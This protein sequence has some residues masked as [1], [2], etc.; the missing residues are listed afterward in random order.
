MTAGLVSLAIAGA[1]AVADVIGALPSGLDDWRRGAAAST[2]G[3][4]ERLVDLVEDERAGQADIVEL[5]L[6]EPREIAPFT[7]ALPPLPQQAQKAQL[8]APPWGRPM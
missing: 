7:R 1:V 5:T 2:S 4:P 8:S 3:A 6:A